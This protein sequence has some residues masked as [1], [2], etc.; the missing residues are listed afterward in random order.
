MSN[1]GDYTRAPGAYDRG[2]YDQ[3]LR[4]VDAALGAGD[5]QRAGAAAEQALALGSESPQ[6][7]SLAAFLKLQRADAPGAVVLL[8]RAK[9]LSPSDINILNALGIALRQAGRPHEARAA[10]DAA[11]AIDPAFATAHFNKGTVLEDLGAFEDARRAYEAALAANPDFADALTR[12]SYLAALRGEHDEAAALGHRALTSLPPA[13]TPAQAAL[14]RA[15]S[16]FQILTIARA[17]V[18][19]GRFAD[20]LA[21]LEALKDGASSQTRYS[22]YGLIGDCHHALGHPQA[23]FEHFSRAKAEQR[24]LFAPVFERPEVE[25]FLARTERVA[26]FVAQYGR[27]W[28]GAASPA[29][30]VAGH[31]F[32]VGFPRSGTTLLETALS[33]HPKIASVDEK[34]TLDEAIKAFIERPDGLE[35]LTNAGEE[36]LAPYREAYWR[37][38]RNFAPALDG[39]VLVD[40]VPLNTVFLGLIAKLFPDA[41]ILFAIRDP[42][43][44]VFSCFR[45]VFALNIAMYEFTTLEGTARLYDAVMR[46]ADLYRGKLDLPVHEHR[47]ETALSDFEGEARRVCAFLGVPWN[48][49]VLDFQARARQRPI[50]TPS[51][52]QVARGLFDGAGQ[53]QLYAEHLSPVLPALAPWVTRY[54]YSH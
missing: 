37:T 45:H 16:E 53:W 43:D 19:G 21:R 13:A 27:P 17:E 11:T 18:E 44:V 40:K 39:K 49:A 30:E 1:P 28:R 2:R 54:G 46:L 12:L 24:A 4:E 50:N 34:D 22:V 6:L 36:D 35:R 8:E 41:K 15:Q 5:L 51:S 47:Y 38:C 52:V 20:A 31:A 33:N 10:L 25:P 23:A 48:E 42:R 26:A 7:L 3:F 32:L 14:R 29:S 9:A